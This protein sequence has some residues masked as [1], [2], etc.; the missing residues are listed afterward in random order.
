[1]KRLAL[2]LA[3]TTL[4]VA[5]S[6]DAPSPA[7]GEAG[8]PATPAAPAEEAPQAPAVSGAVVY[9]S[10]FS[11]PENGLLGG[12]PL[13]LSPSEDGAQTA[14]VYTDY[15]ALNLR[16]NIPADHEFFSYSSFAS[17]GGVFAGDR[18]LVDLADVSVQVYGASRE[19]ET[20]LAYGVHCREALGEGTYYEAAISLDDY[21]NTAVILRGDGEDFEELG[22]AP[23]PATATTANGEWN[24]FRLDCIGDQITFYVNGEQVLTATDSTYTTGAVALTT[25]AYVP[26]EAGEGN[27]GASASADFDNLQISEI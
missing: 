8:S 17:T 15:D 9:E 20:G 4:L 14:G 25:V 23:L 27:P 7:S 16:A 6:D 10:D 22:S 5:C 18:E 26:E 12:Q 1:M 2:L 19:W 11:S 13:F 3:A 24:L 21:D